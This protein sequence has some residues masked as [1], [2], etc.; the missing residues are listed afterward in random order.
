MKLLSAKNDDGPEAITGDAANFREQH[1]LHKGSTLLSVLPGSR[2]Q[3]VQR[4]LPIFESAM[5]RLQNS[6]PDLTV[7]IPTA[8]PGSVTR[9]VEAL[10]A[11]WR[12]PVVLL[13]GASCAEKYNALTAS[14][15]AL[16][17]SGTAVLQTHLA[18]VPCV[19]AYRAHPITEYF[20]RRRTKLQFI[21]L[22]NILLNSAIIPEA[23]F[24]A[25]TAGQIV[26]YL[27]PLIDD[28]IVRKKQLLR[29]EELRDL[30]SP[31]THEMSI[32]STM[33]SSSLE[34]RIMPRKPS[35]VAASCILKLLEDRAHRIKAGSSL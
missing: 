10:V 35:F 28:E 21:S 25:C 12:V 2:L 18:S 31:V 34:N 14:N 27:R 30:L 1:G 6:D 20:I 3:E 7:V 19:A 33:G 32:S 22:P 16:C 4:M 24:G 13:P 15:A 29:A 17:T 11:K 9:A 23:L 8:Q 5:T 26:S